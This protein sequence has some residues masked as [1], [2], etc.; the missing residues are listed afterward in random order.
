MDSYARR[1]VS[2]SV[3]LPVGCVCAEHRL[4]SAQL[5]LSSFI[6]ILEDSG[7]LAR[8]ALIADRVV[9]RT[10]ANGKAFI[11]ASPSSAVR[12]SWPRGH[13]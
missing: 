3:R 6:G 7:Y 12:P 11:P 5:L 1:S 9:M 10:I 2:L 4:S 8:A 13:H